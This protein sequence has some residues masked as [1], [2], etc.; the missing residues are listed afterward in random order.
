[1]KILFADDHALFRDGIKRVL[2]DSDLDIQIIEAVDFSQAFD[3]AANNDDLDLALL[4]LSM[5]GMNG[6]EAITKFRN[7]FSHLPLV[8]LSGT[9]D[10]AVAQRLLRAGISGYITKSSTTKVMTSAIKLVMS[11]GVYLPPSLLQLSGKETVTSGISSDAI[12]SAS[13]KARLTGRQLEVLGLL[14]KGSSNKEIARKLN[15]SSTTA[16][17]HV[18]AIFRALEVNNRTEAA[19]LATKL[20]L[21]EDMD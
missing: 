13:Q 15:M 1:M 14:A 6:V 12:T 4:D 17:T 7:T 16:S 20:G 19:H 10:P 11:G 3:I 2:A 9:E 5:P 21:L 18:A 8:V